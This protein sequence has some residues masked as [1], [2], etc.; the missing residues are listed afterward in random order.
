MFCPVLVP[1]LQHNRGL[2]TA[3]GGCWDLPAELKDLGKFS[4]FTE[5]FSYLER[6]VGGRQFDF[7]VNSFIVV[8]QHA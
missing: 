3:R 7:S 2:Q 6:S 5:K 8:F 4:A 1:G